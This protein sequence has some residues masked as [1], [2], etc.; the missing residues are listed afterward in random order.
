MV[1][2]TCTACPNGFAVHL[3]CRAKYAHLKQISAQEPV[4]GRAVLPTVQSLLSHSTATATGSTPEDPQEKLMERKEPIG[5][6]GNSCAVW[7]HPNSTNAPAN[8]PLAHGITHRSKS[9]ATV[10]SSLSAAL[11]IPQLSSPSLARLVRQLREM[12]HKSHVDALLGVGVD[13]R[14]QRQLLAGPQRRS[15]SSLG[16]GNLDNQLLGAYCHPCCLLRACGPVADG[17]AILRE[18]R[19]ME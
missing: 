16:S 5:L 2:C 9:T 4:P 10:S 7:R 19:L 17:H 6:H 1:L 11:S 18:G 13:A 12:E 3:G 15:P 14:K 8:A